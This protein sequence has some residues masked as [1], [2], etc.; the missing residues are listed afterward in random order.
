MPPYR[1]PGPV[2]GGEAPP[3]P[4][5]PPSPA[6]VRPPY[7]APPAAP[8]TPPAY[9]PGPAHPPTAPGYPPVPPY[10][11]GPYGGGPY[12][13]PPP[14]A[15]PPDPFATPGWSW[16]H[17]PPAFGPPW[18]PPPTQR[19]VQTLTRRNW[20]WVVGICT[21]VAAFVGGLVGVAAGL[22]S[23][24]TIVEKYFPNQSVLAQ[25]TAGDI[26]AV[27]SKVEPAVV[28]IDTT[29]VL[30]THSGEVVEGAGTGMIITS[31]GEVLTNNHVVAGASD[32]QVTLFGQSR[33]H[34]AHVIGTDPAEDLALVQIDGVS[35]LPTVTL[36]D[37]AGT[38][39]GD[40][41]I[42]IGNALA[43]QGG[44]TVTDG[45]ISA[46]NRSLT[47]QGDF[48]DTTESLT[49]LIQTDAPINPGNSGGPLVDSR[50]QVIGMNTAVATSGNGNAPAQNIGFAIAIDAIKSRLAGLRTGGTAGPGGGA[51]SH[52][53][54]AFLGVV[55]E[56]V[57]PALVSQDHLAVSSGALVVGFLAGPAQAAGLRVDDVIT[58]VDFTKVTGAP[59]L[60]TALL[61]HQPGQTVTIT[62]YQG[63]ARR[64]LPVT[65]G[66]S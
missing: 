45:I 16:G 65:L 34:D 62:F 29:V 18:V 7:Q 52:G 44:P 31:G 33:S 51:T 22:G 17:L 47:A 4:D 23:Q 6:P 3:P 19:V 60:R 56:S 49:G 15:G 10:G 38:Q 24:Q 46:E 12:P 55:V 13:F 57:T 25:P 27:L 21:V 58:A 36:G 28:S 26:Q 39:V 40:E 61:R 35:G 2:G 5:P 63:G 9:G 54:Q 43:L 66:S 59:G 32:V 41:V 37:S 30:N 11:G 48:S 50:G 8:W 14:Y 64:S 1:P 53:H 42:A 20:V